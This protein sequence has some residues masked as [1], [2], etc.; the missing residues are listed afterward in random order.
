[1]LETLHHTEH[2]TGTTNG[3][4][5]ALPVVVLLHGLF[6]S[7]D[8]LSV[9]RKHLQNNFRVIN[10]DL[11]DHGKS[12]RSL[13]FSFED[14][15]KQV[16][17]TLQ[18]LE[19]NHTSIIGHSLGGH[20]AMFVGV[21]DLR[22]K[23][24]VSSCGWTPFHDYYQGN[25]KGWT[26]P[27]Y[28]PALEEEYLLD[29]DLVPFDFYEVVAALAPRPFFSNSPLGDDNFSVAGVKKGVAEASKIYQLL[30]AEDQIQV[31]YPDCAHD[32]PEKIRLDAYEFIQE[33]LD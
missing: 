15:A 32:F 33:S 10:I 30:G 6:G 8:N 21:F 26:S 12:P 29:P 7:S 11:P 19:I 5:K 9:V 4:G 20:N 24:I 13:R 2:S 31:V 27:R 28:M 3:L 23:V 1:M 25:I 14:Y 22:L 18:T 16:I 17:D